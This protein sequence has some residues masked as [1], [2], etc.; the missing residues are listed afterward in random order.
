MTD[1]I[2]LFSSSRRQGNTGKL[3]DSLLERADI[4]FIDLSTFDISEYDYEH[5]NIGDDFVPLMK[6]LM[7]YNKIIFASPVYWYSVT[8][9]MKTF[10]DRIS[11]LLDVPDFLDLGRQLRG[12]TGFVL[13]TSSSAE[14]SSSFINSFKDT[15]KYLGMA[16]GGF[17]H[18]ECS[19][20]YRE[21]EHELDLHRFVGLLG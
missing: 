14:I 10:I 16:Y 2:V 21:K 13:A 11:D 15:F 19:D 8:P 9:T 5:K 6:Q 12:K 17:L 1:T 7:G 4:A 20:T 3:L 18:A